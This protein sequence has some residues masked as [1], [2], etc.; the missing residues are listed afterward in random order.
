M[1][2]ISEILRQARE[3][4]KLT[5]DEVES[6]TKIK[7]EFLSAIE[8]GAFE[9]LPSESYALGFVKNYA[10]Y[11]GLPVNQISPLFRR[12][13]KS[14]NPF[15][16][17]PE[18]RRTQH[19]FNRKFLFGAKGIFI[20]I[21]FLLIALYIFFQYNSLIFPPQLSI[22]S[23]SENQEITGNVV[24]VSG[25][26]NAY[27]T[28]FISGQEAYVDIQG[29]FEKSIYVFLGNN[30]VE[31]TAKNRFGKQTKKTINIRVD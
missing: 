28:V 11:L 17:V 19:K 16:I 29:N 22:T 13:Y 10:K 3:E 6:V 9:K 8:Q 24:K 25:K 27:D 4:K 7:K 2:K 21:I 14:K 20:F 5:L 30:K 12:E 26:T 31:I 15:T 1:R 18:F 23:P